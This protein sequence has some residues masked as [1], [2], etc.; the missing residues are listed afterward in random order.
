MLRDD[1]HID[2]VAALLTVAM[3]ASGKDDVMAYR[4]VQERWQV[5]RGV[6]SDVFWDEDEERKEGNG[7]R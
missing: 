4:A 7:G 1:Q 2:L 3:Y 6:I 5:W